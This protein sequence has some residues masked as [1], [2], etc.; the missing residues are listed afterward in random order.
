MQHRVFFIAF[1]LIIFFPFIFILQS[2]ISY[3]DLNFHAIAIGMP[4]YLLLPVRQTFLV[5][6]AL[7]VCNKF[8]LEIT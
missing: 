8:L 2:Y 1:S 3:C 5:R 7:K 4:Q 6:Y